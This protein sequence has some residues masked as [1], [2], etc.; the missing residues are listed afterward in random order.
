MWPE[1]WRAAFRQAC[2]SGVDV[3]VIGGGI[4]GAGVA[5]EAAYAGLSVALVEQRDFASGASSW[6]SKLVHGGLRYLASDWRLTR[7][8]VRARDRLVHDLPDLVSPLAFMLPV[9]RGAS[10]GR[11]KLRAGLT[12]YDL[13]ARRR[14]SHYLRRAAFLGHMPYLAADGLRG[15]FVYHD[16][17]TDDARLVMRVLASAAGH[18]ARAANYVRA[19][20]LVWRDG[21]VAGALVDDAVTDQRFR[22]A[23]RCVVNAT[24]AWSAQLRPGAE[25]G[26]RL[27]PL[28][29][30]HFVFPFH[31]L[32]VARAISFP[33]PADRRPVFA[34][35]WRGAT[36]FGTT[37]LDHDGALESP[38]MNAAEADYL[39]AALQR[40]FPALG[41]EA[42]HALSSFAGVRPVIASGA[43]RASDESRESAIVAANG[44]IDVVGGKLT[45]FRTVAQ[46]VREHID[47]QL[48]RTSS[49]AANAGAPLH[50]RQPTDTT[51]RDR[52]GDRLGATEYRVADLRGPLVG[53][54]VEHLDDLM[55]RRTRLG[56][57]LA[58]GGRAELA[59]I[60]P[61][62]R[63]LL[64]WSAGRWRDE[65]ERYEQIW[66]ALHAPMPPGGAA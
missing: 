6:S 29:G 45:T 5:L 50:S 13:L 40:Y 61:W 7:E 46:R 20:E 19:R 53:E 2:T 28:R 3:L 41:I 38:R 12:A 55:L 9:Y 39:I 59:C 48:Q 37:D 65:R 58:E 14:D 64:G 35:P 42:R 24:G 30:S 4:T 15:G 25:H 60:E 26:T 1:G 22:V 36:L 57:L 49:T 66:Q 8:S 27:R 63:D 62:C 43:R 54:A 16:A 31:V 47:E 56:L 44:L 34:M 10:P 32:P 23:A 18:G 33:H 17:V 51:R 52:F 21:R 11:A